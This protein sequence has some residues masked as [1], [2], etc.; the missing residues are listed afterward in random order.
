MS[1]V[2]RSFLSLLAGFLLAVPAGEAQMAVPVPLRRAAETI[3]PADLFQRLGIIAHDSMMGRDTPSPGLEKT[4]RY[5]ADQFEQFGLKPGG[6]SG[7]WFQRYPL[8]QRYTDVEHSRVMF[9][10]GGKTVQ[11][12]FDRDA[13]VIRGPSASGEITGEV[14]LLGG[15]INASKIDPSLANDRIVV[16]VTDHTKGVRNA[17][18][19]LF[20]V[21]GAL[22]TATPKAI[23][24]LANEEPDVFAR[25]AAGQAR[26]RTALPSGE[27]RSGA[28]SSV[29]IVEVHD[30]AAAAILKTVN[31]DLESVR[32]AGGV[33]ARV[34]PGLA[35]GIDVRQRIEP[36]SAPNTIGIL[37]G[38]DPVLKNEYLVYSA[39]MDHIGITPGAP[40]SINNGADDDG[41][42]T[43][44]V[45][46]LAEAFSQAGVRPSG[47]G[48]RSRARAAPRAAA[49][50]S[51]PSAVP[52]RP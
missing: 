46:E 23:V 34:V 43:V 26:P 24:A 48:R 44:T 16:V 33:V 28:A 27:E 32:Q 17:R 15:V 30:R 51:A 18:V 45:V 49:R 36:V 35:M 5:I 1:T 7:S 39:H 3:T 14:Y 37:E 42:G 8:E 47:A 25:R 29:A 38:S 52:P 41:S 40:D 50:G 21:L 12:G 22:R 4:A 31:V 9:V 2:P 10:A 20:R 6:E 13:R 11:A 19:Q